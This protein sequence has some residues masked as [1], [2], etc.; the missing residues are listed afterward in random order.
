MDANKQLSRHITINRPEAWTLMLAVGEREL[1]YILFSPAQ[2]ESL[3]AATVPLKVS[4]PW[5][6]A[7]ENAVYDNELLLDDYGRVA[8]VVNAPHFVVMPSSIAADPY[9]VEKNFTIMFPDDDC[10]VQSC[11]MPRCDVA[12]A[13]GLP[14]GLY[15][16]LM[17][18]FNN[19]PLFH[20]LYPLCEHFKRLNTGT[21][22]SRMFLNLREGAMDMVVYCKGE[23]MMANSFEVRS[24]A[25]ATFL[26]LHTWK[27]FG[28]DALT[29]EVQL[30][31]HR[32]LRDSLATQLR[33]YVR[34]V[35]PAIF[36]A[37]ALKLS[38]NAMNAPLDLI[39]LAT[40]E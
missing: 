40:C 32:E 14:R 21:G 23:M 3:I 30:T 9:M 13:Y 10:E 16:F 31:G 2:E 38:S 18:T 20:H 27:S 39:L 25:D 33:E 8:I 17:R 15:S 1:E 37:A 12:V 36:P 24:T 4:T 22:I 5:M 28:M 11:L 34:F 35:M 7:V 26:A 6:Q 19:A 29:D